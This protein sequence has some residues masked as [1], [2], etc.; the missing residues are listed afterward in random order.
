[1][2][3]FLCNN[4]LKVKFSQRCQVSIRQIKGVG[5]R[6]DDILETISRKIGDEI[7]VFSVSHNYRFYSL[8]LE[9]KLIIKFI[10]QSFITFLTTPFKRI[11]DLLTA[12]FGY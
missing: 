3:H 5:S 11:V 7:Q 1:M 10:L 8:N 2:N 12:N 4:S 9:A 6:H